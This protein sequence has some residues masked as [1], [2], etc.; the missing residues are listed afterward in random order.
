[1]KNQQS[2]NVMFIILAAIGLIAVLTMS[3]SNSE[4]ASDNVDGERMN[5][6]LQQILD[7]AGR[8]ESAINHMMVTN[9][10]HLAQ[11]NFDNPSLVNF[12]TAG[13]YL[14][15]NAPA[16]K[17]CNLYRSIGGGLEYEAPPEMSADE[18]AYEYG[19][20]GNFRVD[21]NGTD[22]DAEVSLHTLLPKEACLMLNNQ[23]GVTNTGGMPPTLS[24]LTPD[25]LPYNPTRTFPSSSGSAV[26]GVNSSSAYFGVASLLPEV[27]GKKIFCFYETDADEYHFFY[28]LVAR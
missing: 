8:M 18:G 26:E 27:S 12:N 13:Y 4:R 23:Q 21:D 16:D 9:G 25:L 22:D 10:C 24:N 17:S 3:L 15:P 20:L 19:V 1:M 2:G 11:L 7:Y 14:N 6:Q 28:V 5:V